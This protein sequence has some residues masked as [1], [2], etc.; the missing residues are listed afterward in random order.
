MENPPL[1]K[2]SGP[3]ELRL[4]CAARLDALYAALDAIEQA[5]NMWKIDVSLVSRVRIVVEE[6]FTNTIKY[7]YGGECDK[8]VRVSLKWDPELTLMYEDEAPQ[9]NPLAWRAE[10]DAAFP[11]DERPP[12]LAGIAMVVGLSAKASYKRRDGANCLAIVFAE[13]C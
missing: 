9:F 4:D 8:P 12:G 2:S 5:C 13:K 7:G 1:K 10:P 11:R 6:L 3:A